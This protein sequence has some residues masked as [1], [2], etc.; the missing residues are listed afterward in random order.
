[1]FIGV[2]SAE[3]AYLRW[4]LLAVVFALIGGF[5]VILVTP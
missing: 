5:G 1:M 4:Y 3:A 2:C